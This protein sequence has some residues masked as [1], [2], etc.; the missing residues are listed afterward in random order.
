MY[1]IYQNIEAFDSLHN[2]LSSAILVYDKCFT[3]GFIAI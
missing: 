3:K 2:E 1:N